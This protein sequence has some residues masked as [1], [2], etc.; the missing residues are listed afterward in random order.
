MAAHSVEAA[1]FSTEEFPHHVLAA[2]ALLWN[3]E[4]RFACAGIPEEEEVGVSTLE[5]EEKARRSF[6]QSLDALCRR[7][8]WHHGHA[9][10]GCTHA[11]TQVSLGSCHSDS[12]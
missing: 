2:K 12:L 5:E 9:C 8:R 3:Q 4:S 7:A 11:A 10:Q 6:Q 1:R